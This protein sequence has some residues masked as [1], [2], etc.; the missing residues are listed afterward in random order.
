MSEYE[1]SDIMS[2]KTMADHFTKKSKIVQNKQE[3]KDIDRKYFTYK[4][5]RIQDEDENTFQ[6]YYDRLFKKNKIPKLTGPNKLYEYRTL[7]YLRR[8]KNLKKK[9]IRTWDL[10]HDDHVVKKKTHSENIYINI[11][12]YLKTRKKDLEKRKKDLEKKS[13]IS[14]KKKIWGKKCDFRWKKCY[15]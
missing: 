10:T 14:E 12:E 3:D 13:V 2:F 1:L 5:K 11:I 4:E 9:E 7:N 6:A 8:K 15:N